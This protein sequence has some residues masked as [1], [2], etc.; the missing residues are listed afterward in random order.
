MPVLF[1]FFHFYIKKTAHVN[2]TYLHRQRSRE[3]CTCCKGEKVEETRMTH[4]DREGEGEERRSREY[5][6]SSSFRPQEQQ[7]PSSDVRATTGTA[8]STSTTSSFPPTP[9]PVRDP[10]MR[11]EFL[12]NAEDA[13][14]PARKRRFTIPTDAAT[15]QVHYPHPLRQVQYPQPPLHHQVEPQTQL[16]QYP[17]LRRR[18]VVSCPYPLL[19]AHPSGIP[20]TL[21]PIATPATAPATMPYYPLPAFS[22]F[23]YY[24]PTTPTFTTS[25][26]MFTSP[27]TNS[28]TSLLTTT[29]TR[30]SPPPTFSTILAPPQVHLREE[31]ESMS[32]YSEEEEEEERME[33]ELQEEE[34]EEQSEEE[35]RHKASIRGRGS[36]TE[37]EFNATLPYRQRRH[38]LTAEKRAILED[39]FRSSSHPARAEKER[40]AKE[41]NMT[42]QQVQSWYLKPLLLRFPFLHFFICILYRS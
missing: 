25:P 26:P 28:T 30:T 35:E 31:G 36:G 29:T 7:P 4:N 17:M 12:L 14:P 37:R 8:T 20:S 39:S 40:L 18:G 10:R 11:L 19:V 27:I 34:E 1:M 38:R 16:Q 15:Q 3:G 9:S 42:F 32:G 24:S 41:L 23:P 22:T 13:S 6:S 33:M 5:P 21:S 2:I